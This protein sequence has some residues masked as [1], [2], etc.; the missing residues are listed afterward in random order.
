VSYHSSNDVVTLMPG[1]SLADSTTYTAAVSGAEDTA[2]DPMIGAF[3]PSS[4]TAARSSSTGEPTTVAPHVHPLD[5][6][7]QLI[8]VAPVPGGLGVSDST[9]EYS[10]TDNTDCPAETD[11]G[12]ASTT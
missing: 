8:E 5:A 3:R 9:I 6:G 10:E 11:H 2:S 4:T 7:E 1:A 12:G